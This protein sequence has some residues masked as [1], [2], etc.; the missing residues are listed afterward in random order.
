MIWQAVTYMIFRPH[1]G[2]A[3]SVKC[4]PPVVRARTTTAAT[5][6][7]FSF[8]SFC[9]IGDFPG[10]RRKKQNKA[11]NERVVSLQHEQESLK[12]SI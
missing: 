9:L 8:R 4:R 7:K 2:N 3:Q 1:T 5:G 10:A 11:K 6:A 12:H